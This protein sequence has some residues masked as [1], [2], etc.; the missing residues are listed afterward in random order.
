VK[1]ILLILIIFLCT[2][3]AKKKAENIEGLYSMEQLAV[4]LKE[5]YILES[6][7]KGLKLSKDSTKVIF[8]FY[9]KQLY[10]KHNMVDSLYRESFQYYIDDVK[11]MSRI[12]EIIADS[13]SLEERLNKAKFQ[14]SDEDDDD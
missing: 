13:L 3:C 10:E 14:K 6:K 1:K 2:F 9:E 4:F 12:Y 7:L 11:A 8:E 5:L